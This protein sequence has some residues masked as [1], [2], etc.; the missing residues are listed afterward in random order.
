VLTT[1]SFSDSGPQTVDDPEQISDLV[2]CEGTVVWTDVLHPT[3]EDL[4]RIE[5]EFAIHPLAMEDVSKHGQRPKLEVYQGHAFVV[6]YA[7]TN[8]NAE[9]SEVDIFV[10]PN[11]L[12]TIHE[13]SPSGAH[14]DIKAVRERC[15]RINHTSASFL[16][17]TVLDELVDSYFGAVELIG[18]Q[19][20]DIE[21][22]I[23]GDQ[24]PEGD[25]R[26]LQR[27]MLESRKRL[28]AFRRRVVP[29]REVLLMLLR[30]DLTW[31]EAGTHH[32]FQDVLDHVMR[33]TDEIDNRRELLGNAV[34]AH[35]A[36]V[37][38]QMNL[39]MKKMTSWGAILIVSTLISGIYGMN[40]DN[41]P[42]LHWEHGFRFA[43]LTM[44]AATVGLYAY[45]KKKGWI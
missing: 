44:L 20:D 36:M 40:F 5:R 21:E 15:E 45:F 19:I 29:L 39:T 32:Y 28:L 11:W 30:D 27:E 24:N 22:R 4:A 17:Y 35:L 13:H 9:L 31:I 2:A 18:D 3:P 7:C 34:D 1:Y 43:L 37:S 38:N 33:I 26:P 25:E 42:E 10:G 8:G 6:A 23:F 12:V 16:L 14:F 41:M